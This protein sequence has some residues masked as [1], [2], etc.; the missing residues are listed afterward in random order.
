[1]SNWAKFCGFVLRLLG[2]KVDGGV[3]PEK[4]AVLLVVP[5]TSFWDFII[6]YIYYTSLGAKPHTLG[7]KE[8]FFWPFN[9][10][11]QKAGG[12]PLDRKDP[13]ATVV[14]TINS[15]KSTDEKFHLA[16]AP[17]GT[18]KPVRKW[19]AGY[20]TIARALDCPVYLGHIDWKTKHIGYTEKFPL[21]D[22]PRKDTEA[23]QAYYEKAGY[24]GRNPELFLTH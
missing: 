3:A 14:K 6:C 15:M 11:L 19:K 16:I 21:T 4:V 7:K 5:H 23:I 1:M 12:I 8:M 22:D 18:R 2:W 9:R 20:H 24:M 13:V 17:E 10:M